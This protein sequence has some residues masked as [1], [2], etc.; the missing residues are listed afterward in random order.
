LTTLLANDTSFHSRMQIT[1]TSLLRYFTHNNGSRDAL[2][3]AVFTKTR[4]H[5]TL[6]SP[7]RQSCNCT[8]PCI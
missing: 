7:C 5:T 8:L 3:G 2:A 6:H 1:Q 4:S